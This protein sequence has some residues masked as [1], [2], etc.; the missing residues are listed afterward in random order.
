MSYLIRFEFPE[1]DT[2]YAGDH[3]G[4]LGWAQTPATAL[5]FETA[6]EARRYLENGYG[7]AKSYGRVVEHKPEPAGKALL[8]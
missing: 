2:L 3:K 4:A 7:S 5:R 1:G 8:P 6:E